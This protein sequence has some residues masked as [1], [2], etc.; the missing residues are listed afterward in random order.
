MSKEEVRKIL[1]RGGKIPAVS[2]AVVTCAVVM[3]LPSFFG[4]AM[5]GLVLGSVDIGDGGDELAYIDESTWGDIVTDT[6]SSWGGLGDGTC[7]VVWA[8]GGDGNDA[9]V[10]F[11]M[12]DGFTGCIQYMEMSVL[13]GIGDD[14]FIVE[15]YDPALEDWVLIYEYTSVL[16]KDDNDDGWDEVE[17]WVDHTV[18]FVDINTWECMTHGCCWYLEDGLQVRIVATGDEWYGFDTY[19]QLGVDMITLYGNGKIQ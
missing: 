3:M 18:Y 6:G 5:P 9:Y 14:S 8:P 11:P 13:D 2:V 4:L 1:I 16:V 12:P 17:M 15:A 19:G 10:T 7:R